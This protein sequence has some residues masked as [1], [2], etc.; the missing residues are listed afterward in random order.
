MTE[1]GELWTNGDSKSHMLGKPKAT[2]KQIEFAK[3]D[4]LNSDVDSLVCG[5]GHHMAAF[6]NVKE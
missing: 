3:V 6:V 5:F 1:S 2:G 4:I